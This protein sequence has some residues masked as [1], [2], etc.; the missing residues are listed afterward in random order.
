M[1]IHIRIMYG[2]MASPSHDRNRGK[3]QLIVSCL[4]S[5]ICLFSQ[6]LIMPVFINLSSTGLTTPHH[7]CSHNPSSCLFSQPPTVCFD[8]SSEIINVQSATLLSLLYP[9]TLFTLHTLFV[10]FVLPLAY[11][12]RPGGLPHV[13]SAIGGGACKEGPTLW[14]R[15]CKHGHWVGDL[16]CDN[17]N[18]QYYVFII[19]CPGSG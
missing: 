1:Y 17:I 12:H 5:S 4:H 8:M 11:L 10:I 15:P 13:R 14:V 19:M 6:P 3:H 2:Q 9:Y 7:T 18:M 16:W